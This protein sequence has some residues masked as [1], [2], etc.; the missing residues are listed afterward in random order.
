M[1]QKELQNKA[2]II[3]QDIIKMLNKAGSGHTAGALG[4][5][6]IFSCLYFKI[7]NHNPKKPNDSK[8][9]YLILSNGHV[10]PV[11]YASLAESGYFNKKKLETLRQIGSP[12]QGHP[13]NTILKGIE[14]S[15]GPLG[16]GISQAVGLASSLKRDNK[17]NKVFCIIG[18]GEMQEGQVWEALMFAAK[19][20]LDNLYV[21]VDRN[22]IQIDGNT[23]DVCALDPLSKKLSSFNFKTYEFDGNSIAQILHIFDIAFKEKGKP[24]CLI[25]NTIAGKGVDFIE[26]DYHWHGKAPNDNETKMALEQLNKV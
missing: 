1:N 15:S 5:A 24:I 3:R 2:N 14:N 13:H 23:E 10:C 22:Y 4:L 25:A 8:R 26:G 17:K 7:M 6:D 9:D 19:E 11:L 21:I 12:L 16:Q 20:K 18:D